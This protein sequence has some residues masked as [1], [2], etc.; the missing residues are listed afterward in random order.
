MRQ[1]H[2]NA[3]YYTNVTHSSEGQQSIAHGAPP[4]VSGQP[5]P[6]WAADGYGL[7]R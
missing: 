3:H 5:V 2:D 7:L 1:Q 6:A 4:H